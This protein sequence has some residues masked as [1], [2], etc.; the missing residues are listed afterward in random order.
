MQNNKKPGNP[1][2]RVRDRVRGVNRDRDRDRAGGECV[3]L[4][5]F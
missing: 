3:I 1:S 5:Q 4:F 2:S